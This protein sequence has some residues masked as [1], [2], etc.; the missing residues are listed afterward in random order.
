M[1]RRLKRCYGADYL[2]FITFSCRQ[3][4]PLLGSPA[5]RDLFLEI[6]EQVRCSY[7][8]VV[9]AYVVMPEHVHLLISEPRKGNP[10]VVMQ[11]LKQRFAHRVLAALRIDGSRPLRGQETGETD[12]V[13]QR[14][15]YDFVVWSERKQIE[16]LKYMHRNPVKRG[17]VAEPDQWAWSS[18]RHY[19]YDEAGP[20]LV[21]E[22]LPAE[23]KITTPQSWGEG[24]HRIAV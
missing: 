8:F 18:F 1:P 13:W 3:R 9:V 15:F 5:R 20:V 7:G 6:L 10:S 19:A 23:L 22:K 2:H 21:N 24:K 12:H 14:R 4:R 17:L 16:K 11:V